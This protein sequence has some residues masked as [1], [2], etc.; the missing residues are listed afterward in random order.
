[1]AGRD[2]VE[3]TAQVDGREVD[4]GTLWIHDRSGQSAT[5]RYADSYLAEPG[6]YDLDPALPCHDADLI[7]PL[8]A[9]LLLAARSTAERL[10]ARP[11]LDDCEAPLRELGTAAPAPPP[12]GDA[13][14]GVPAE[15]G[16]P[17]Q[18]RGG[19]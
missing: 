17:D 12:G 9:G 3:V 16:L 18:G 13:R 7:P 4:A 5:F 6:S 19:R 8:G 11:L 15:A 1:M 14:P 10:G 2:P